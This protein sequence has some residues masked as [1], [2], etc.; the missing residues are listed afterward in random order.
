MGTKMNE[1]LAFKEHLQVCCVDG[2]GVLVLSHDEAWALHDTD[3]QKIVALIDGVRCA[4]DIVS[5]LNGEL[6]EQQIRRALAQLQTSGYVV[7]RPQ[8]A[9]AAAAALWQGL[10]IDADIATRKLRQATVRLLRLP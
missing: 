9:D 2:E 7:S 6:P 3:Y 1:A 10:G 4:E 5:A 8:Y